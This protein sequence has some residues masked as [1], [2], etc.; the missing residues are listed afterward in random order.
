[1]IFIGSITLGCEEQQRVE[2]RIPP[3]NAEIATQYI[4]S[5]CKAANPKSDEE[6]EDMIRAAH[7]SAVEIYGVYYRIHVGT[8]HP[9]SRP[10]ERIDQP[11]TAKT[12][13][14]DSP[15]SRAR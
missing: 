6:P 14:R 5:L 1:M 13:S 4:I 8:G 15:K 3:E 11:Q 7:R 2:K 10:A 12:K 9:E